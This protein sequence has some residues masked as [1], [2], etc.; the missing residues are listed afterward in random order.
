MY[1]AFWLLRVLQPCN[2]L[3]FIG[4]GEA[5]WAFKTSFNVTE[6]ELASQNVDL[7]FDGLDTFANVKL[8]R[9]RHCRRT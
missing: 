4:V 9:I 7:I 2:V 8:V 5:E 6:K 3:R 1:V